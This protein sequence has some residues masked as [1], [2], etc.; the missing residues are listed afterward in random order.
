MIPV[1]G[2]DI[3]IALGNGKK[4]L[5]NFH[6][7]TSSDDKFE[8]PERIIASC[9]AE[10]RIPRGNFIGVQQDQRPFQR[11]QIGVAESL[12]PVNA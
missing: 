8:Y 4:M 12:F 9:I 7:S 5:L 10:K 1:S 11:I 2:K 3:D 6:C